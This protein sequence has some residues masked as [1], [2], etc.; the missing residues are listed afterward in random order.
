M[1][2]APCLFYGCCFR[3]CYAVERHFLGGGKGKSIA[4]PIFTPEKPYKSRDFPRLLRNRG[5]S[6]PHALGGLSAGDTLPAVGAVFDAVR[7]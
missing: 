4:Y 2:S 6:F 1:T 5:A 7:G 3:E